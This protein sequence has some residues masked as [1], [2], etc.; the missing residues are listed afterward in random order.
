MK[1]RVLVN[2]FGTV[3][4]RV[5]H[6]LTLQDDIELVGV[7]NRSVNTTCRNML[8][9]QSLLKGTPLYAAVAEQK[10]ISAM[11]QSGFNYQGTLE[12]VLKSGAVDIV[13]DC[14]PAEVDVATK[15]LYEKYGVKQIYQGGAPASIAPVSFSTVANYD[16][17][18]D[19]NAI[20]VVSC[21]TTSLVR[22]LHALD[23]RFGVDDVFAVLVRRTTD[24]ADAKKGPVNAVVPVTKVPSH[25]GPDVQTVM[26]HIPIKTMACKIPTTLTHTHFVRLKLKQT[27]SRE[28]V[29]DAFRNAPRIILFSSD[30]GYNS[31][32][33]MIE[34]FRDIGRPRYDMYEVAIWEEGVN[35]EENVLYWSHA[36][37]QES[38][39]L[40][41][42]ID[43]IRAL[44]GIATKEESMRKTDKSLGIL[45]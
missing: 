33:Q 35:I 6:A 10:Y 17:A 5:A 27:A 45:P 22:T 21:N 9:E 16:A 13:V 24:P 37:H 38:I 7:A 40:P 31:T 36:V 25:H 15:P 30:A 34:Y 23:T 43:A 29:L 41:E 32:S 39:V 18:R 4:K 44:S 2:G 42:N 12:D 11:Q 14:T 1:P 8:G 20:R 3:G 26:P 28:T 19:V